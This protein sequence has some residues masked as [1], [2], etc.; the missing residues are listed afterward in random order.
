MLR[1]ALFIGIDYNLFW[2]LTPHEYGIYLDN[3]N[4][5]AQI[6][7]E[8]SIS[9]AWLTAKLLRAET[10]PSLESL[11]PRNI[12]KEMTDEQMLNQAK[13]LNAL[14]GGEVVE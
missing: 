2:Q 7:E 12:Q 5:K 14:F 6:E 11:L 10:I 9:M 4:E 3:Y 1:T 13:A 8:N